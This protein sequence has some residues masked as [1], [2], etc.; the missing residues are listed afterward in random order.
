MFGLRKLA[1]IGGIAALGDAG[2]C[3]ASDA[4]YDA[5]SDQNGCRYGYH[6]PVSIS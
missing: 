2:V 4:E 6:R 5:A 1:T 3:R